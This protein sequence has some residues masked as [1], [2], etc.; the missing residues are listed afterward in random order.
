M[1][2]L[3]GPCGAPLPGT[4]ECLQVVEKDCIEVLKVYDECLLTD[5]VFFSLSP[6]SPTLCPGVDAGDTAVCK[7][8]SAS[9]TCTITPLGFVNNTFFQNFA[10]TQTISAI[11]S[12]Y[13]PSSP[14]TP[15]C[16]ISEILTGGVMTTLWAPPGTV[17]LCTPVSIGPCACVI[18]VTSATSTLTCMATICKDIRTEA[19]VKLLVPTFGF[20]EAVPCNT[21]PFPFSCS[22]TFSFQPQRCP[23]APT[24]TLI[25]TAGA[26]ITGIS[27]TVTRPGLPSETAITSA[28]GT[29]TFNNP[30][31]GAIFGGIDTITFTYPAGGGGKPISF[32]VPSE[33]LDVTTGHLFPAT[34]VCSLVFTQ[35]A[36]SPTISFAV[37]INGIATTITVDP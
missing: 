21:S 33:F 4:P 8:N 29:A 9:V 37:T 23:A 12:I 31:I 14:G 34:T 15:I 28:T 13:T 30:N 20:C 3:P 22:A 32:A 27:V 16:V 19:M 36:S 2:F 24:I 7:L 25:N 17:A 26:S 18:T 11:V 10:I 5:N 1:A 6:I 35:T